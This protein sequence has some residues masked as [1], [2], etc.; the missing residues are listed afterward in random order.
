MKK[1]YL[2]GGM[3]IMLIAVMNFHFLPKV[4]HEVLGLALFIAAAVPF[5]WNFRTFG[6]LNKFYL[7]VDIL[8]LVSMLIVIGTGIITSHYIFN[9]LFDMS[10]QRNITIHKLH[11]S[12]PFVMMILL[13]LHLGHNWLGFKQRLSN[14]LDV[15]PIIGKIIASVLI[16]IGLVG[17]YMDQLFDRLL[18]KHIFGTAATQL[19]L[20]IYFV[21]MIGMIALFTAI[22]F[23]VDRLIKKF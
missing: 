23:F 6:A 9:G 21:L 1:F 7:A 4:L 2:D 20:G 11:H 8:L 10:L 14:L 16:G 22:G 3:I 5:C 17:A 18:M 12:I 15:P 19:P 13:G